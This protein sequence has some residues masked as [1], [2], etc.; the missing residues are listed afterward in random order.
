ML[1]QYWARGVAAIMGLERESTSQVPFLEHVPVQTVLDSRIR[2]QWT[3]CCMSSDCMLSFVAHLHAM[4]WHA[5]NDIASFRVHCT[6]L[7]TLICWKTVLRFIKFLIAEA[8]DVYG[9]M[10]FAQCVHIFKDIKHS[11]CFLTVLWPFSVTLFSVIKW[12]SQELN[13]C[14][15]PKCWMN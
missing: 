3:H 6:L 12:Y 5:S 7:M 15:L 9:D 2:G 8:A 13:Q 1:Q 14:S 11:F 4:T 10:P